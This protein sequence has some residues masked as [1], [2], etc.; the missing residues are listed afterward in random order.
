M[1][2]REEERSGKWQNEHPD[3]QARTQAAGEA[4]RAEPK[5]F[6]EGCKSE[7]WEDAHGKT[8]VENFGTAKQDKLW[9]GSG[10]TAVA[11][12]ELGTVVGTNLGTDD[13]S[14]RGEHRGR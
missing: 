13:S 3:R 6:K 10:I 1:T 14:T 11:T 8:V 9:A 7:Q 2:S 4:R 5:T 12:T